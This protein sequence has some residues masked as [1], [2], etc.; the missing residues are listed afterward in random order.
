MKFD[1][2]DQA[3][4]D[5]EQENLQIIVDRRT[6]RFANAAGE[7]KI[8]PLT[9][10]CLIAIRPIGWLRVIAAWIDQ[11]QAAPTAVGPVAPAAA[12]AVGYFVDDDINDVCDGVAQTVSPDVSVGHRQGNVLARPG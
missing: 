3:L 2:I 12:V 5:S 10:G 7:L 4:T 11:F 8:R 6:K 9:L 1:F